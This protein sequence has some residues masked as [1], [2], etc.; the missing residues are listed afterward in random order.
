LRIA[1][2]GLRAFWLTLF[3]IGATALLVMG[4][5]G[6]EPWTAA[7]FVAFF[8]SR[9]AR[10]LVKRPLQ[11][12]VDDDPIRRANLFLAV[13]ALGWWASGILAAIAALVG[14]GQEWLYVAPFFLV[15]GALNLYVLCSRR[16][17]L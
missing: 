8:G 7:A 1:D 12:S 15:M 5:R 11:K 17:P 2:D 6:G 4:W 9:V 10:S 16:A 3:A 13:T 14:E